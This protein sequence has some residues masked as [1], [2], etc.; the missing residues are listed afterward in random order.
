M[1]EWAV[2]VEITDGDFG[3]AL[4][5]RATEAR[6]ALRVVVTI[7]R[8]LFALVLVEVAHVLE[9]AVLFSEALAWT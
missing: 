8:N 4:V 9:V 2:S 7:T 3:P 6:G 5:A 1:L